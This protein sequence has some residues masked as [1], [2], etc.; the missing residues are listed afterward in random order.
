[1]KF[2]CPVLALFFAVLTLAPSQSFAEIDK[3]M[4]Y[5]Q[6]YFSEDELVVSSS[7]AL[8]PLSEVAE[9]MTIVT[10]EEIENM[11]AHSVAE[12][13]DRVT[14]LFLDF[15]GHDF[16]ST[17]M[18]KIQGS[19]VNHVLILLDG[20]P[21]NTLEEGKAITMSVP[22]MI[23]KRIEVIKGPASSAWGSSLGGVINIITK[24]AGKSN[25]PSGTISASYGKSSVQDYR[26]E[27]SGMAGQVGYYL[28]AGRQDSDGLRDNRYFENNTFYSKLNLPLSSDINLMVTAG[29]SEPD[30]NFGDITT[31]KGKL[32]NIRPTAGQDVFFVTSSLTA[33]ISDELTIDASFYFHEQDNINQNSSLITGD[34][35]SEYIYKNEIFGGSAKMV[36]TEKNN[37]V[38][39]GMDLKEGSL[40]QESLSAADPIN[41]DASEW[42][43]FV[44][45]TLK[46]GDLTISPGLRYD[47]NDTAGS[48]I[49]P[50]LGSTYVIRK[51]TLLRLSVAR[52][53]TTPPATYT[54]GGDFSTDPNPD[55]EPETVWSYQA[56]I[57]SKLIKYLFGKANFF[58]HE[59]N[60][61]FVK[62][63]AEGHDKKMYF[64]RGKIRREGAE[65]ELE[66][67]PI[68]NTS[69]KTGF[70]YVFINNIEDDETEDRYGANVTLKYDDRRSFVAQLSG[71][72]VK[73][74]TD[75][76]TS[77]EDGMLWD[78]N[79][80]KRFK[81][82]SN[83]SSEIFFTAH[84]IFDDDRYV[85]EARK[86][87]NA[88][89][90]GGV[91]LKF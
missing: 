40:V 14:G 91:R 73:W 64:N 61:S 12:V 3:E 66:T 39:A 54:S 1:M 15:Q 25:V 44:N 46:F 68:H 22:V 50:S 87:P 80:R 82:A 38:V 41:S 19:E 30:I 59:Q 35:S 7:R 52:G 89:A 18:L 27:A 28:Y 56:G 10:A 20:M 5:L 76:N 69:F 83:V 75:I 24:D 13:L 71:S 58:Y 29:Y 77:S 37:T 63:A 6:M 67:A 49:S 85:M 11:N 42:A 43:V 57:E 53:F 81:Y 62:K 55:L 48:F 9:N 90:E 65:L 74:D 78:L 88:W 60:N 51:G 47:D 32:W 34:L 70:L 17:D 26:A 86:N 31:Y 2:L 4:Q 79:L 8:K 23:I 16:V 33:D 45:D 21:Y 72:Y 36:W 84:N